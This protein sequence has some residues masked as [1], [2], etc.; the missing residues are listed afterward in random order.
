MDCGPAAL[1]CLLE[2]FG[3]PVSYGRLRDACQTNVDGT[4]IDDMEEVA[5]QLGL[6]VEQLML[7]PDLLLLPEARALPA[8]LVV[9]RP[10]GGTHFIVIWR[11]LGR[12]VQVMDPSAGRRWLSQA[13]LLDDVY[14]H[15]LALPA[16][17]WAR[18]ARTELRPAL[19]RRLRD[20]GLPDGGPA[21]LEAACAAAG[22]RALATLDAVTRCVTALVQV[23][24][25][26]PG[27]QAASVFTDLHRRVEQGEDLLA[28]SD[29]SVRPAPS[30]SGREQVL[31]RGAVLLR[32]GGLCPAV[33]A[34]AQ[35]EAASVPPRALSPEL[36]AALQEPQA[37]PGRKLME[38]LLAGGRRGPALLVLGLA[39]LGAG[40]LL[41]ALFLRGVIDLGRLLE[42]PA[43]RIGAFAALL[44]FLGLLICMELPLMASALRLGRH[45]ELRLRTAFLE[46]VP[47]LGERYFHSRPTSDMTE[48]LH[49]VY[50]VRLLPV[51]GGRAVQLVAEMLAMAAGL[52]WL[53]P[54]ALVPVVGGLLLILGLPLALQV[55]LSE[56]DL[57]VRSYLGAL[58][59]SYLDALLGLV[60]VR[61]H[62]AERALRREHETVLLQWGQASRSLLR[63]TVGAEA[64]Q[65]LVGFG[66]AVGLLLWQLGRAD[67]AAGMLLFAYFALGIPLIA[68]ELG[69]MVRQIPTLRSVMLRVLE[70]LGALEESL[71]APRVLTGGGLTP[72]QAA[73]VRFEGVSVV[74]GGH[75][76]LEPF[77]L[78]LRPGEHVAVVG[79]SGAGKSSLVGLLL[80]WHAP[81]SGTLRVDGQPLDAEALARL[82]QQ[83]AWVDPAVQL[84]N[85]SFLEN[86]SYGGA[87]EEV[88]TGRLMDEAA[89][90]GVL[91][92]LPQGLHSPLG[93]G[94]GLVSG[95]EGQRVRLGRAMVRAGARLVLLDEPFRGLDRTQRMALLRRARALWRHATLVC[96][97][98]DLSETLEFERVLV[99]EGGRIVEDAAPRALAAREGS[100]YRALLET[101]ARVREQLW[102]SARWRRLTLEDGALVE[103]SPHQPGEHGLQ[104]L[105]GGSLAS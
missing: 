85:M 61:T 40:S 59:R 56:Y 21:Y 79:P 101:E 54:R 50:L 103:Q 96:V 44:L 84:W 73:S 1:K 36:V 66:V 91:E 65:G 72:S 102:A 83:T 100:R 5:L 76:L 17:D 33:S 23:G 34:P 45:L 39:V 20:L 25:L 52:L 87:G 30:E 47:R 31:L 60:A 57:R 99:L 105:H 48:R 70:P 14:Q 11:R 64:L 41:E 74:A 49:S 35:E 80:G 58:A 37:R 71:G 53:E 2:G 9:C 93:E 51:L 6:D 19:A 15:T 78:E 42:S 88:H 7:P 24:G 27:A 12:L 81:A 92:A 32:A 22:W 98:H 75:T 68:Q 63:L 16:E 38:L 82:R 26:T 4:S 18:W 10:N 90:H 13:R 28:P 89:L 69:M 86:L 77:E 3:L 46:K 95:G 62:G 94:G 29:W 97:T 67:D 8:I 43:Q 55:P 104:V